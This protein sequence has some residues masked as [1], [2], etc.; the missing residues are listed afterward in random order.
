MFANQFGAFYEPMTVMTT[1]V[2]AATGLTTITLDS[3]EG[4][5]GHI[6]G[7]NWT[8]IKQLQK[9]FQETFP[10]FDFAAE[11]EDGAFSFTLAAIPAAVAYINA[12][13]GLEIAMANE[14]IHTNPDF[15]GAVIG[16]GGKGLR[17]IEASLGNNCT[18]YHDEGAFY[19]KFK[20]DTP[21][22]ERAKT[23]QSVK[24]AIFG[25]ADWLEERLS[26][27]SSSD[28]G[29]VESAETLADSEASD[30]SQLSELFS[31]MSPTPSE[32]H[33]E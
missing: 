23:L 1:P 13:I 32:A 2:H 7:P 18:I 28:T 5:T 20:W 24:E 29:S 9:N 27:A 19:V 21:T 15:A 10:G 30:V 11:Y 31:E 8:R 25:R 12:T 26:D 33:Y 4:V 6:V 14:A 17:N 16:K 3:F 22:T